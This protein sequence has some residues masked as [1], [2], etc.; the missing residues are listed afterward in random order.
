M[1]EAFEKRVADDLLFGFFLGR[2]LFFLRFPFAE[3]DKFHEVDLLFTFQHLPAYRIQLE[4]MRLVI[5][6]IHHAGV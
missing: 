2:E 5:S 3:R 4:G 6:D 1:A